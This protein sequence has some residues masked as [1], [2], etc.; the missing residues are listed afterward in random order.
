[1]RFE[2]EWEST[3]FLMNLTK[4]AIFGFNTSVDIK[5]LPGAWV[6]GAPKCRPRG[7]GLINGQNSHQKYLNVCH[8]KGQL[9]GFFEYGAP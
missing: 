6:A 9:K 5:P 1:M 2:L 3:V 7:P 8:L 4:F